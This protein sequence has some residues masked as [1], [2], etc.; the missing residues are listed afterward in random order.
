MKKTHI[1]FIAV[2][3]VAIGIIISTAGDASTYVSFSEAE[4]LAKDEP[5]ALV[6]VVGQLPKDNL[7]H[8]VGLDESEKLSF[9][10]TMVDNEGESRRVYYNEP[11]P[12]D[13]ERSEQV[14]V[15]GNMRGEVFRA[16][17]ILMKCPSKYQEEGIETE[18]A[19]ASIS[20]N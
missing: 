17:K 6:H 7:G 14:V 9:T 11:K 1:L 10:F 3:A 13:F 20:D 12:A 19:T 4:K 16:E 15:I 18:G 2:I 8:A 5:K